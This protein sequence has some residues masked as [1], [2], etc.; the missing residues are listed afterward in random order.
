MKHYHLVRCEFLVWKRFTA[1]LNMMVGNPVE[2]EE[3]P[4]DSDQ[5]IDAKITYLKPVPEQRMN[6]SCAGG[7]GAFIDQMATLLHTDT[8]GLNDLALAHPSDGLA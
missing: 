7:T 6:G 2:E 4:M 5:S 1:S 8:P 3:W